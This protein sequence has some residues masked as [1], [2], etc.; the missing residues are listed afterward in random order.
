MNYFCL[1]SNFLIF[2]TQYNSLQNWKNDIVKSLTL[3][4]NTF[5]DLLDF[6]D[7]VND[8]LTT[9]DACQ[10]HFDIVSIRAQFE[11]I[12]RRKFIDLKFKNLN[13]ELTKNYLE[14]ISTYASLMILLSK[15]D[16]R[17]IVLGLYTIAH[18]MINGQG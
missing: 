3:Y 6:K 14:L 7:H 10:I 12:N 11:L 1:T 18:E 13:V 15:V 9:I 4:Y 5:V 16:D 17:K 2:K 8:L